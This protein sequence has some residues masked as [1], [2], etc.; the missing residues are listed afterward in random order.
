MEKN[1]KPIPSY[2]AQRYGA[3]LRH[4]IQA[5]KKAIHQQVDSLTDERMKNALEDLLLWVEENPNATKHE[6]KE[7]ADR[8]I[9]S[10]AVDKVEFEG[11]LDQAM[12]KL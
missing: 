1:K 7:Q 4:N 10:S 3:A 6:I 2:G 12:K 8:V 9:G 11:I 5:F